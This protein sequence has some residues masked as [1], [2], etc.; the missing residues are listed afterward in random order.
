LFDALRTKC[1]CPIRKP[2]SGRYALELR[3]VFGFLPKHCKYACHA[4]HCKNFVLDD[5][6]PIPD[7]VIVMGFRN[8]IVVELFLGARV[9][10]CN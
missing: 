8:L 3:N 5:R 9:E 6:S 1:Q 2:A 7:R 10:D 4:S